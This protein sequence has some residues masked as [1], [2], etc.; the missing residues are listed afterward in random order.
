MSEE[1]FKEV[2]MAKIASIDEK[3]NLLTISFDNGVNLILKNEN[4]KI[5][6]SKS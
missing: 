3:D 2:A 6:V 1:I 5:T 4:G